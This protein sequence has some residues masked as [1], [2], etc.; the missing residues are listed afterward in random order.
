[1][2]QGPFAGVSLWSLGKTGVAFSGRATGASF[3]NVAIAD[4]AAPSV[5][6]GSGASAERDAGASPLTSALVDD[7]RVVTPIAPHIAPFE[8]V[9]VRFSG[10]VSPAVTNESFECVGGDPD[11]PEDEACPRAWLRLVDPE[12]AVGT[13]PFAF[14]IPANHHTVWEIRGFAHPDYPELPNDFDLYR[15]DADVEGGYA[16]PELDAW[17]VP[18]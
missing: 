15:A 3:T 12:F 11:D 1:M 13:V 14:G 17:L 5:T 9:G 10:V 2:V 4:T 8:V 6:V 7:L 18:R 16:A